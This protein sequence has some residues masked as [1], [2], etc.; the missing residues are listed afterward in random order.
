MGVST[1]SL[2]DTLPEVRVVG[3]KVITET[4]LVHLWMVHELQKC[5]GTLTVVTFGAHIRVTPL[6][7][8]V[9]LHIWTS[10]GGIVD[11]RSPSALL[12][13]MV[14]KVVAL[15]VPGKARALVGFVGIHVKETFFLSHIEG[16]HIK[17]VVV[18]R[19][20]TR[21][22]SVSG[23]FEHGFAE[24]AFT[25]SL[26]TV[27][28]VAST[29]TGWVELITT[30]L[31]LVL[32]WVVDHLFGAVSESAVNTLGALCIVDNIP[33]TRGNVVESTLVQL[34]FTTA[35]DGVV[36]FEASVAIVWTL[37]EGERSAHFHTESFHVLTVLRLFTE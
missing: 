31:S 21:V 10:D 7:V 18:E 17:I 15:A 9:R 13:T 16:A 35:R 36:C 4:R 12:E 28:S 3:I 25:V 1:P 14:V 2:P 6:C 24:V 29:G 26:G 8:G 33:T 22:A 37:V 11:D 19:E 30:Q 23:V 5:V 34:G 32:G 27:D 20:V